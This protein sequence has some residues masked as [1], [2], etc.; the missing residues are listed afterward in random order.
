MMNGKLARVN[1]AVDRAPARAVGLGYVKPLD[2]LRALAVGLVVVLHAGFVL[3]PRGSLL[4][5]GF[6][7]VDVFLVLSGF[8]IT[9][10][11]LSEHA[12]T[13]RISLP[14]F[15][16]RRAVRLLPALALFV[17]FHVVYAV[18]TRRSLRLEAQSAIAIVFYASNVVQS[19]H[20]TMP[21]EL[22]HTWSLSLEEQFYVLWPGGLLLLLRL[23]R[24]ARPV[25]LAIYVGIAT[26]VCA[27][28]IT[29]QVQGYPAAYMLLYS[30]ADSLLA[31]AALAFVWH[32]GCL[33]RRHVRAAGWVGLAVVLAAAVWVDGTNE[34]LFYTSFIFVALASTAM[35]AAVLDGR[36]AMNRVLALRPMVAVGRVSYGLYLWHV[37]VFVL[38]ERSFGSQSSAVQIVIALVGSAAATAASWFLVER[39]FLVLKHRWAPSRLQADQRSNW[40]GESTTL[41]SP[42]ATETHPQL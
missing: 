24:S 6:V 23:T 8:L 42:F 30:R 33:P 36:W 2:G 38:V 16:L 20:W 5:G 3:S 1:D 4:R 14:A 18:A 13:N 31:G 15:Y 40:V 39:R 27:R 29:W 26:A 41:L 35:I 34:T 28:F 32:R 22:S 37:A 25:P 9:S 11:L 17:L 19:L 7:G 10:L 21:V 12:A